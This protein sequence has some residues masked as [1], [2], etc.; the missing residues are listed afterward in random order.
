[1]REGKWKEGFE[2]CAIIRII[3]AYYI[4]HYAYMIRFLSLYLKII[5]ISL[6]SITLLYIETEI[7]MNVYIKA[8]YILHGICAGFRKQ[9]PTI[10]AT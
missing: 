1:M 10:L 8:L 7:Y 4:L 9:L 5:F 2:H 6:F 3:Q